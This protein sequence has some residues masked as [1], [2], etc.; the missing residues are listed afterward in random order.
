MLPTSS[1]LLSRTVEGLTY[2]LQLEVYELACHSS[3]DGGR[4]HETPES[5]TK[6]IITHSSAIG[7][8]TMF[9]AAP[10]CPQGPRGDADRPRWHC[11]HSGFVSQLRNPELRKL[12]PISFLQFKKCLLN[13]HYGPGCYSRNWGH[14]W[15][16]QRIL[17]SWS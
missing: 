9:S 6:H 11:A 12:P 2:L 5:E 16:K 8:S 3:M 7:M 17:S 13:A 10:L 15:T 14:K 1:G 4:R